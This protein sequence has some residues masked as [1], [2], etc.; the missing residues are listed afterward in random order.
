[1]DREFNFPK[2]GGAIMHYVSL[3]RM[4]F[5]MMVV[6]FVLTPFTVFSGGVQE[7]STTGLVIATG[8]TT[9]TGYILGGTIADLLTRTLD[10]TI[11]TIQAT[12]GSIEN[13][14]LL[15]DGLVDIAHS[16]ELYNSWHGL[17]SFEGNQVRNVRPIMQYGAWATHIIVLDKSPITKIEDLKGKRVGVGATG[18]GNAINTE[19]VLRAHGITFDDIR[20]EYLSYSEQIDALRDGTIDVACIMTVAPG[21]T[22]VQMAATNKIRL[23]PI[24]PEKVEKIVQD[25]AIYRKV[26]LPKGTYDGVNTDVLTVNS[27][28]WFIVREGMDEDLVYDIMKTVVENLDEL[29]SINA[30]FKILTKEMIPETLGIPLHPG[31]EKYY[32]EA[33]LI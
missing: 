29:R 22:I 6:L 14:R 7:Q 5:G 28:G 2:Q 3:K 4:V 16:T 17:R 33:G 8:S 9:S 11:V 23:I 24:T 27:P 19:A 31:A 30:E 26:V 12:G 21:S 13:T 25:N 15:L 1:M 20:P 18:S 10:D 32:K